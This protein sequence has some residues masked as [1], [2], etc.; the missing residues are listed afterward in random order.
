MSR[1]IG[2]V[3]ALVVLAAAAAAELPP[4][5]PSTPGPARDRLNKLTAEM[6][7]KLSDPGVRPVTIRNFT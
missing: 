2:F 1:F 4:K 5:H 3:S 7:P 6:A